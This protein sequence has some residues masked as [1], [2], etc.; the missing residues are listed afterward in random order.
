ME[1]LVSF[2]K[3][4]I[5]LFVAVDV[6]AVL[7]IFLAMTKGLSDDSRK[8]VVSDAVM[9]AL[10]LALAFLATGQ[11][12]FRFLSITQDDFRVGG[13]VLLLI[14]AITDLLFSE[15]RAE[16]RS[17]EGLGVVPIGIPLIIGP[18]ALTTVLIMVTSYGYI[19]TFFALIT[20]LFIVWLVFTHS[21]FVIQVIGEEGARAFGKVASLFI[22]AIAIMMIRVG[23]TNFI[24]TT[25]MH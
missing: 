6:L 21:R 1:A 19:V 11:M 20:N 15:S 5:P 3:A 12:I 2:V 23:I 22:A 7:P 14:F 24:N 8:K 17:G 4:F 9:G 16:R 18:A 25:P 13:G 10:A